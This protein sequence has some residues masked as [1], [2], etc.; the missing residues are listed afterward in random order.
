MP[1]RLVKGRVNQ[2]GRVAVM[3]GP[4][5]FCLDPSKNKQLKDVDLRLLVIDIDSLEGPVADDTVRP[6]GLAYQI[7]AW[8]P[9]VW[10][11]HTKPNISLHLTEFVD[12]SGKTTY[13]KVP[14]HLDKALV[15][16]EL[17]K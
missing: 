10:Y 13:F 17:V 2:A 12:P 3:R 1:A 14:N 9:G 11:P 6:N 15:D 16:D 7:K 8:G 5:L 4:L